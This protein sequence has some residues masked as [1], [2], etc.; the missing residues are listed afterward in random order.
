MIESSRLLQWPPIDILLHWLDAHRIDVKLLG[1][2]NGMPERTVVLVFEVLRRLGYL[3]LEEAWHS[4]PMFQICIQRGVFLETVRA[5]GG[6]DVADGH[7]AWFLIVDHLILL[8]TLPLLSAPSPDQTFNVV[9]GY[10][11]CGRGLIRFY[12]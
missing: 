1:S 2:L 11:R 4:L 7:L 12:G 8:D 10:L 6:Q 3:R 5:V 9:Y